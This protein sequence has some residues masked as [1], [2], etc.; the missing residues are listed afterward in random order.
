MTNSEPTP[1]FAHDGRET[2]YADRFKEMMMVEFPDRNVKGVVFDRP[3]SVQASFVLA[4]M[5]STP[6]RRFL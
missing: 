6:D 2:E 3:W 1:G 4:A 5:S